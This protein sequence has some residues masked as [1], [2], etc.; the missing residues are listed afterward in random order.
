MAN[1]EHLAVL[2]RGVEAWNQWRQKNPEV[3]P[4]LGRAKL[5]RANLRGADLSGADLSGADLSGADLSGANLTWADLSR[6][7]LS[8]AD[9]SG[10]NL[11]FWA[12]LSGA[13]LSGANLRDASVEWTTF[14]NVD[15]SVVKGL[16]TVQHYGPSTVGID[17]IYRSGGRIPE[18]FL[19]G[20]GI[21]ESFIENMAALVG[22]LQPG[23]FYS[24]FI[25]YS[26]EDKD[27]VEQ[28][29]TR[30]R[31]KHIRVW[32]DVE[33]MRGGKKT[34]EQIKAAVREYDKLIVVLSEASMQSEWVKTEIHYARQREVEEGRQVL[35]PI[36]LTDFETIRQ[37]QAFDADIG[38]DMAKE[39]REYFIP[40]FSRWK[41]QEEFEKAFARLVQD[42]GQE[43]AQPHELTGAE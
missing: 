41:V 37:W 1:E 33:G 4:D 38:K 27:F 25:S 42:L 35:F 13:N 10:A 29:Y 16:E 20:A 12:D 23:Q 36:R 32:Y 5:A 19:R 2:K 43:E 6:A 39:I 21:P 26:H 22:A 40:D 34:H 31:E 17:T 30:L 9:L 15:L 28:L 11:C 24:C 18:A 8:G 7:D 14:G 3:R